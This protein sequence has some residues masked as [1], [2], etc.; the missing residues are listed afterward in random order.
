MKNV[1]VVAGSTDSLRL[2]ERLTEEGFHPTITNIS[3]NLF[4]SMMRTKGIRVV[5]GALTLSDFGNI[6]K[7]SQI[8][9][10]IDETQTLSVVL[11]P[12]LMAAANRYQLR[13]Y[14]YKKKNF[15]VQTSEIL[16]AENHGECVRMLNE[17]PGRI[18]LTIGAAHLEEYVKIKDYRSRL[19][20]KL[21]PSIT[22]MERC[23]ELGIPSSNIIAMQGA[24]S[25]EFLMSLIEHYEVS[26]IV[27]KNS[28][29]E[30]RLAR[31]LRAAQESSIP[32]VLV[33]KEPAQ[34]DIVFDDP[35]ALL[36]EIK[37]TTIPYKGAA[38]L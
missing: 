11:S 29:I 4:D 10:I 9:I 27:T 26:S 24:V 3:N 17:I 31:K 19:I 2:A 20:V 37:N 35:R 28:A 23:Y 5:S 14:R 30:S 34:Y 33:G 16:F 8:D 7:R 12:I 21:L 13:Y 25:K 18:L 1:L 15:A 36:E 6:I 38:I 22:A 32:V